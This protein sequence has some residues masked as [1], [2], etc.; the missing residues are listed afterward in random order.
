MDEET[1]QE[2]MVLRCIENLR[3]VVLS[4]KY[5][6]SQLYNI[7]RLGK[8]S[9]KYKSIKDMAEK[10]S[11]SEQKLR[12]IISSE[13]MKNCLTVNSILKG[14]L[15]DKENKKYKKGSQEYKDAVE[16]QYQDVFVVMHFK[17]PKDLNLEYGLD[18]KVENWIQEAFDNRCYD[19]R[20]RSPDFDE[21]FLDRHVYNHF[22]ATKDKKEIDTM[23]KTLENDK[24][25][26]N[27]T[28]LTVMEITHKEA[29]EKYLE[30]LFDLIDTSKDKKITI[31][32]AELATVMGFNMQDAFDD[33][34]SRQDPESVC[35]EIG[36]VLFDAGIV[37]NYIDDVLQIISMRRRTEEDKFSRIYTDDDLYEKDSIIFVEK[38]IV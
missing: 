19:C 7:W 11:I 14:R 30:N 13:E 32:F 24:S 18:S 22:L 36:H 5:I 28:D 27:E 1:K 12:E 38:D 3:R 20:D 17:V 33:N 29:I 37:I 21:E 26:I 15:S 16:Q 4:D 31:K 34:L 10:I 2:E 23:I 6:N 25:W 8:E 35:L 9:G